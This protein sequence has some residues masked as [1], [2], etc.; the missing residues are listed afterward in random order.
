MVAY[1]PLKDSYC[2]RRNTAIPG[3]ALAAGQQDVFFVYNHSEPSGISSSSYPRD[4]E[5]ASRAP[6]RVYIAMSVH[7]VIGEMREKRKRLLPEFPLENL[8]NLL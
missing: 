4:E 8:T 5:M 7:A 3:D 1:D 6:L 2:S